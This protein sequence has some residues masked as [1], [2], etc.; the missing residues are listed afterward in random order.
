MYCT[1]YIYNHNTASEETPTIIS[2]SKSGRNRERDVET[3]MFV[4]LCLFTYFSMHVT[5]M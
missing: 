2:L 3:C 4:S 5:D 1:L